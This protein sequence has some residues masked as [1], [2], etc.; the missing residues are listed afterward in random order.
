MFAELFSGIT[1]SVAYSIK[2]DFP[3]LNKGAKISRMLAITF[4]GRK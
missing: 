2:I 3:F 1:W 4:S